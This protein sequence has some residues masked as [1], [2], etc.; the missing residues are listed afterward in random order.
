VNKNYDK[1]PNHLTYFGDLTISNIE[2]SQ[3]FVCVLLLFEIGEFYETELH[4]HSLSNMYFFMNSVSI[5]SNLNM[6]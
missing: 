2:N 1:I 4:V 5:D 6:F 3:D